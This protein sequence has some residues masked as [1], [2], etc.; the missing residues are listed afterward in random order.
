MLNEKIL[1]NKNCFISVASGSIGECFAQRFAKDGCN[2]FLTG[3]SEAKL[4]NL[5]DKITGSKPG[6]IKIFFAPGDFEDE[7]EI[8]RVLGLSAD[9]MGDTDILINCIGIT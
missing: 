1:V 7:G 5:K 6:N 3:K 4:R 8:H 2:L 9:L